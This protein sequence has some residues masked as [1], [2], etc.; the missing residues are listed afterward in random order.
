MGLRRARSLPPHRRYDKPTPGGAVSIE[1]QP[2]ARARVELRL[3]ATRKVPDATQMVE[4]QVGQLPR[5]MYSPSSPYCLPM[6]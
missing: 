5:S 6:C 3:R 2:A 4:P 1:R